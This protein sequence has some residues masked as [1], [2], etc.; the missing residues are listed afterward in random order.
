MEQTEAP[1]EA[2][3][4][5]AT[6]TAAPEEAPADASAAVDVAPAVAV[7]PELVEVWRPGG[8]SD[9]RRPRH[10]R[11][12]SRHQNKPL[13]GVQPVAAEGEAGESAKRER[14]GRPRREPK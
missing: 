8:R 14:H 2:A 5:D 4:V 9:E 10:D 11:N 12:R 13:E 6:A 1:Q 7:A 3:A